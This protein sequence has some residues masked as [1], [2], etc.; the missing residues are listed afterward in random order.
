M[1]RQLLDMVHE[2]LRSSL[3]PLG[4]TKSES[5]EN[6]NVNNATDDKTWSMILDT[7]S[8]SIR[9]E[10]TSDARQGSF[11][12]LFFAAPHSAVC[13]AS[14]SRI[15]HLCNK[16]NADANASAAAGA[17]QMAARRKTQ[18]LLVP[19]ALPGDLEEA[20]I[21]GTSL[22][23][24]HAVGLSES[25][26]K[27]AAEHTPEGWWHVSWDRRAPAAALRDHLN[28]KALPSL[29]II[30]I[31]L[32]GDGATSAAAAVASDR[33]PCLIQTYDG[34]GMTLRDPDGKGFPWPPPSEE[35]QKKKQPPPGPRVLSRTDQVLV[36][37][38]ASNV[39]STASKE[40][41]A[42][43]LSETSL[44]NVHAQIEELIGSL[45]EGYSQ[46]VAA[47]CSHLTPASQP[48]IDAHLLPYL[49][50]GLL[51]E[52]GEGR[53][54]GE[55]AP[56]A[57]P[58]PC[59][60]LN[61][62]SKVT[63]FALAM[64]A[65]IR[66][67]KVCD[68]LLKRGR[69][70]GGASR[71]VQ[72]YQVIQLITN[73]F[74]ETLPIPSGCPVVPGTVWADEALDATRQLKTLE[75]IFRLM[76]T[77]GATWQAVEWPSRAF[78]SERCL[79]AGCMLA[80][81]D[82]VLRRTACD[83]P[84]VVSMCLLE[85]G[86]YYVSTDV[87]QK[88]R[89]F[90]DAGVTMEL[91]NPAHTRARCAVLDYF[92]DVR[93]ACSV[94]LFQ[95][96]TPNDIEV[97]KYGA[98]AGFVRKLIERCGYELIPL[99]H[100]NPP[101]EF[102][103]LMEWL[104]NDGS[105]LNREHIEFRLLRD[106]AALFRFLA[107][108]ET[109][110]AEQMRRK[111]VRE[112]FVRWQ[113]S[114]DESAG[115]RSMYRR[116]AGQLEPL[117]W[118]VLRFRGV[119]KTTADVNVFCFGGRKLFWGEGPVVQSP[120][121]VDMLTGVEACSEDDILYCRKL[122]T[123]EETLS[124]EESE[125]LLSYLTVPYARIPLVLNFFASHDRVTYL[126]NSQ[127]QA[128]FRAVLFEQGPWSS[129]KWRDATISAVPLRRTA[130]QKREAI[131]RELLNG[132]R[133]SYAGEGDAES[134]LGAPWGLLTN[135]LT[136]APAGTLVPFLSMLSTVIEL[137]G[138]SV[139]SKDA[140][141]IMYL[142]DLTIGVE[143]YVV[144]VLFG[145][146]EE[147]IAPRHIK[148]L[149]ENRTRLATFL[150]G[151][152]AD[153]ILR[154]LKEAEEEEDVP[155]TCVLHAS[156]AQ[157]W[158]NVRCPQE[159]DAESFGRI[160]GSLAYVHNWHGFG[161]G[162]LRSQLENAMGDP[163]ERLMR[164]LQAQGIDTKEDPRMSRDGLKQYLNGKPLYLHIGGAT[165]R[166]PNFKRAQDG[167]K[168]PPVDL[169]EARI[170]A[171]LQN[172]RR[173][174]VM[175]LDRQPPD[176]VDHLLNGV[177][178]TA[179]KS[180]S[181]EHV[182]WSRQG[183]GIGRYV[184]EG[185]ELTV[186][187]QAAEVLWRNEELQPV[188]DSMAEFNDFIT[189]FGRAPMQCGVVARQRH[190]LWVRVVGTGCD[191]VEWDAPKP[192]DQGV[193]CP[194]A[195]TEDVN[196]TN[197][198]LGWSC[199]TCTMFN[200]AD[201]QNCTACGTAKAAPKVVGAVYEGINY[202]RP[203]DPY[204]EGPIPGLETH[205]R[206]VERL[207][208]PL[209]LEHYPAEPEDKKMDYMFY[210]PTNPLD[211]NASRVT[212]L[213]CDAPEKHLEDT[214]WKEIIILR[215][216]ELVQLFNL[217]SHGRRMRRNLV[218]ASDT[219]FCLHSFPVDL[220]TRSAVGGVRQLYYAAGNFKK[221]I[222]GG[223]DNTS[224][225]IE[226]T[227]PD[228]RGKEQYLPPRLLQGIV[229][230]VLLESFRLWLGEDGIVRGETV[231]DVSQWFNYKLEIEVRP[232]RNAIVRRRPTTAKFT[233]VKNPK[234]RVDPE[235]VSSSSAENE[236]RIHSGHSGFGINSGPI[237]ASGP[238]RRPF[239]E[240][241]VMTL[242]TLGFSP[243]AAKLALRSCGHSIERAASWLMDPV[244]ASAIAAVD[245]VSS[246][247]VS[248][249][250]SSLN[251]PSLLRVN[252]HVGRVTTLEAE[253][254]STEACEYALNLF[255][256]DAVLAKAWLHDESNAVEISRL[257]NSDNDAGLDSSQKTKK[258]DTY[259]KKNAVKS[260]VGGTVSGKHHHHAAPDLILL[261]LLEA[262]TGEQRGNDDVLYRL[263]SLLARI[264]DLSHVLVWTNENVLEEG[265]ME[266][267]KL[268]KI[269]VIELPRMKLRFQPI[270]D[271]NGVV[272]LHLLGQDGWFVSET[273]SPVEYKDRE[274]S[275]PSSTGL[276][277]RRR[278]ISKLLRGMDNSLIL[279]NHCHQFQV[280]VANHDLHRPRVKGNPFTVGVACDR[281]SVGWQTV[282]QTR[283]YLY[284]VHTSA[285]FLVRPTLS[286]SLYIVLLKFLG[287]DYSAAFRLAC[288]V[289]TDVDFTAEEDWVWQQLRR[290]EDDRHPDAHAVR[291]KLSLAVQYSSN[292]LPWEADDEM[293]GYLSKLPHVSCDC[294]LTAEEELSALKL[295]RT[296]APSIKN[297]I[298]ILQAL[299]EKAGGEGFVGIEGESRTV[300]AEVLLKP[301]LP[302]WG[303]QPWYKLQQFSAAH[304]DA[305]GSS[306]KRLHYRRPGTV[307]EGTDCCKIIWDALVMADEES[308][309]N[310][311]LGLLFLYE[312]LLGTIT[313]KVIPGGP[314]V[315]RSL[316]ELLTRAF[317][318]K[319][320]RWGRETTEDGEQEARASKQMAALAA[321]ISLSADGT[322]QWPKL[323]EDRRSI[324]MLRR[325]V[326]VYV[327]GLRTP[328]KSFV[329]QLNAAF[330][331]AKSS[332][333]EIARAEA[334]GKLVVS[335]RADPLSVKTTE[336]VWLD[337]ATDDGGDVVEN[338]KVNPS[339]LFQRRALQPTDTGCALR[340][341]Q[342]RSWNLHALASEGV[343]ADGGTV[344]LTEAELE[345]MATQPLH[346]ITN[347][348]IALLPPGEVVS[349]DLPFNLDS[350]EAAQP[351]VAR[352]IL[353]RMAGDNAKFA[354]R[355]NRAKRSFM[356]GIVPKSDCGTEA[357]LSAPSSE[358]LQAVCQRM[359]EL[360]Q[361]LEKQQATDSSWVAIAMAHLMEEANS[362]GSSLHT[363]EN[364]SVT[365]RM[366]MLRRHASQEQFADFEFICALLLSS[367]ADV[368]FKYVNRFVASSSS[369]IEL[370][371]AILLKI[372]RVF[373]ANRS[374]GLVLSLSK[375]I[376][377]FDKARKSKVA[378]NVLNGMWAQL[379]QKSAAC[380]GVLCGKRHYFKRNDKS[381]VSPSPNE[382]KGKEKCL[383]PLD[384]PLDKSGAG[385]SKGNHISEKVMITLRVSGKWKG[386]VTVASEMTVGA[387]REHLQGLSGIQRNEQKLILKGKK[388][389]DDAASLSSIGLK[390]QSRIMIMIQRHNPSPSKHVQSNQLSPSRKVVSIPPRS[391]E[392]QSV[393]S[394]PIFTYDPRYLVFEFIFDILLYERQIE[395]VE[396][397]LG[398][399]Q[400]GNSRVQQMIMGAGKTT[401]VAP[402][403][404][405]ILA[406]GKSLVMQ[407]MPTAL[408][409]QTRNVMRQRFSTIMV[410]RVLTLDF[411][412][413]WTDSAAQVELLQAK[414]ESCLRHRDVVCA[415][416]EAVK[417]LVLKFIEL[418][419]SIEQLDFD[420]LV[421]SESLRQREQ[422]R[423]MR[424][425]LQKKS[426]MCDALVPILQMWKE[427]VL[428]MDEVD[429]LL[430][431]LRS[432][433]NFPIGQ[434][435]P[436]DL[437]GPRWDLPI[438]LMDAVV[439]A[440]REATGKSREESKSDAMSLLSM[441][442]NYPEG[443]ST[444]AQ[445][446]EACACLEDLIDA[447]RDGFKQHALQRNPHMVLL[448]RTWY[449]EVFRPAASRWALLWLKRNWSEKE[450]GERDMPSKEDLLSY[451][452]GNRMFIRPG[453]LEKL[454]KDCGGEAETT[455]LEIGNEWD[456]VRKSPSRMIQYAEMLEKLKV[457]NLYSSN[458]QK[459][460]HSLRLRA[461]IEKGLKPASI[462]LL[463]LASEWTQ[464]LL[465]HCLSKIDRVS[466]GILS[467]ADSE[468]YVT[469]STPLS[470]RLM[471]VP[472]VGKDVPSRSSEFAHP[473]VV[474][475]LTILAFRYEG[476]R[477]TDLR[478]ILTQL[479][480]DFSRETGPRNSRP[481]SRTFQKWLQLT[482][483]P[484]SVLPLHLFQPGD[485]KQLNHLWEMVR[486]LPQLSHY[487]L[488][489]HV[490]PAC[491]N[492]QEEKISAC[493]HE[494]GSAILFGRRVGFSGTPS[495][496]L[497][498]D[499][500]ECLYEPGSDGK[501]L[502]TLC[503]QR[504]TT[505]EVK[506]NWSAKSLLRDVAA[507][508][509]EGPFHAL[510][511]TGA[512]IT[513]MDNEQV[514]RFL[515]LHLP[516]WAEGVVF[517]D[518]KDRKIV[519]E[520]SSGR[521]MP[522]AQCG[523]KHENR[524]TF[525]DQV[526]TTGMDIKQCPSAR[527]VVTIGKDMSFRDYAQGAFRMRGIGKGQRIKLFIIPEVEK[528]IAA[529]L[530][531]KEGVKSCPELDVPAWLLTNSMKL[532]CLQFLQLCVQELY[533]VW[534]R[535]ALRSLI[536]DVEE[537]RTKGI[538]S[539]ARLRRFVPV[540]NEQEKVVRCQALRE[541]VTLFREPVSYEIEGCVPGEMAF[542]R[543]LQV[544]VV[545]NKKFVRHDWEQKRISSVLSRVAEV[546]D[547]TV[548]AQD[549][550]FDSHRVQENEQQ[551]QQEKMKD[552]ERDVERIQKLTRE[553]EQH[554]P[555]NAR[556]LA[557]E[558]L[559]E[560]KSVNLEA[561]EV[562][563]FPLAEF[564]PQQG[565]PSLPFPA[566]A[567]VTDNW[568]RPSWIGL[569][570]RR[571]KNIGLLLEW[572]PQ[573]PGAAAKFRDAL[574]KFFASM[575][576][577]D[578]ANAAAAKALLAAIEETMKGPDTDGCGERKEDNGRRFVVALSLA[579]GETI[580]R[581]IHANHPVCCSTALAIKT[582]DG[583][584]VDS[585]AWY[586]ESK[587]D[588]KVAVAIQC[589]RF[590]DNEF[591][592]TDD[593]L[594]LLSEGL[595]RASVKD[596]KDFFMACLRLRR[597]QRQLFADTSLAKVLTPK[598]EWHLLKS[599]AILEQVNTAIK[600][601]AT[602]ALEAAR[603][604]PLQA[605]RTALANMSSNGMKSPRSSDGSKKKK[606]F[607]RGLGVAEMQSCLNSMGLGFSPDVLLEVSKLAEVWTEERFKE[608]FYCPDAKTL[609]ALRPKEEASSKESSSWRC[610]NC[611]FVNSVFDRRCAVCSRGVTG[612]RVPGDDEWSCETCSFF[613]ST[614][615]YF[616]EMCN[617]S[618]AEY[619]SIRF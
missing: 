174:L 248:T 391:K 615:S 323:P 52:D 530:D 586:D 469:E 452:R 334:Y 290:C 484:E 91:L 558:F 503:S 395:M 581:V 400:S 572:E 455:L 383:L 31:P 243:D 138:A 614:K 169:P 221:R 364:L 368:D 87:C 256:D 531:R 170:F 563:F 442:S 618:R 474:I 53:Y 456:V 327:E 564:T 550:G 472:F 115:S 168:L 13:R 386:N 1:R 291:L 361:R 153:I 333:F 137:G 463:Q 461:S 435:Q 445:K 309:S 330:S 114:F 352:D 121:R 116:R 180:D 500:G 182:G 306:L 213:G 488:R 70:K 505:A 555:W 596:R 316:G 314:D 234:K 515:L 184:A 514:A 547:T 432:E 223:P 42:G 49:R 97:K 69:E 287:R 215:D 511:D 279:E 199:P 36:K 326:N 176:A 419:V 471:A 322:V 499:L 112:H 197:L 65:M 359:K 206:W 275:T 566:S 590:V 428:I 145:E 231:D 486:F 158:S 417:C 217:V 380:A 194:R 101:P 388:I 434:K 568:F 501:I 293:A 349:S 533:N 376:I 430:H 62:P 594:E 119:D 379:L 522:L 108:M 286:S 579:E 402:L 92:A 63:S 529:E 15:I 578:S 188:P 32:K 440:A 55:T 340:K 492:F 229:P 20:K 524:F 19:T 519:L 105:K 246:T 470:R 372:S 282:M 312:I 11:L 216:R 272:R 532:E 146:H 9:E 437:S 305:T 238:N 502:H 416:P 129:P 132:T 448:D 296:G 299:A 516:P 5:V 535:N 37:Y 78:D 160:L 577:S 411:D 66:C 412:R 602:Q 407:T 482:T 205:E 196:G 111:T 273:F 520:R 162:M 526:H 88:A 103:A 178:Q 107:T 195:L 239:N 394:G 468:N 571:L 591:Y 264:E 366:H 451:L 46:P 167:D 611:T 163:E 381:T 219:R 30:S 332:P 534:R 557:K 154:W 82:A 122:P 254:F 34:M 362:I 141:F 189:I 460:V 336:R 317:H 198:G 271:S 584:L 120:A 465:P 89:S 301:P 211:V 562:P 438:E 424:E 477:L 538:T 263:S 147:K 144:D 431:P 12:M 420:T 252:S 226:R 487:Y 235:E 283:Y 29:V 444:D 247:S 33:A 405:L 23:D 506:P 269:A 393:G 353:Q 337:L 241:N 259:E 592:Y 148:V 476:V 325:G 350:H 539:S 161:Q 90:R 480:M 251:P 3:Q 84:L 403:L 130:L 297:R 149:Q 401:T 41:K 253:G 406:D 200:P 425:K 313:L 496:L 357:S 18:V 236:I 464:E 96:R 38:A 21:S 276:S 423:R 300:E 397:F 159:L 181:F 224:L 74:T 230:S 483:N 504:V 457:P 473:D 454:G 426:N 212:L 61:V 266:E 192:D 427:G 490:F 277:L 513:G 204:S 345:A 75:L 598:S 413:G 16:I 203:F 549:R 569:G 76:L 553:D 56:K 348:F 125:L 27:E 373:Q 135:E 600:M 274:L 459:A 98:T 265:K 183:L 95:L 201:A 354:D 28:V 408:L 8:D 495:N 554:N 498:D 81:F 177:I 123:W 133:E 164:F 595:Q 185:A 257:N 384:V 370:A 50:A 260:E 540:G 527:A 608:T 447:I 356:N 136:C 494:L 324:A 609:E 321:V 606:N 551:Q 347:D 166:A 68:S 179:L 385:E 582:R 308:G 574:P 583:V 85:D 150:R 409:E 536:E 237:H 517:L 475:G 152:A 429:V 543:E 616:C 59:N 436:I 43:R 561:G 453:M 284:P 109:R 360:V 512:L 22:D 415:A 335:L 320:S 358:E 80:V 601:R 446:S 552:I 605:F 210:L 218:Y 560:G 387:L 151:D 220:S 298:A 281:S 6:E 619:A 102:E 193:G 227:N 485:P 172:Q 396:D 165:V 60:M 250:D 329:E 339:F 612:Q 99:R 507:G 173:G 377:E 294:R 64:A 565:I 307:L 240:A 191:L 542:D 303:G 10:L 462:K 270:A 255:G 86:G 481:S 421:P 398:A 57:P 143:A 100:P 94:P 155:T 369:L 342:A 315:S 214:T 51:L 597:R 171:Q 134:L 607:L 242:I 207:L 156:L 202:S 617:N 110:E 414:L 295:A 589:F 545:A 588:H 302:R 157:L 613:N 489:Q 292:K 390:D 262:G 131:V 559:I 351:M 338:G 375:S 449:G 71:L 318:L 187:V 493:G 355:M 2:E 604:D 556:L 106:V 441:L 40:Y 537:A 509:K 289:S 404:A 67:D 392:C 546:T 479:K 48:K 24:P 346:S 72:H 310:R 450:H 73:L 610:L 280:L 518:R 128:L 7:C 576:K 497:P 344:A 365:K 410:K 575:S 544:E 523:I 466:Y 288:A 244:N 79:V 478:M 39:A 83:A 439:I 587:V 208:R 580:R 47:T 117:R 44:K 443:F 567:V 139:Y 258:N 175:W 525:Y 311:Q 422:M 222:T 140:S 249:A 104:A 521:L 363:M 593:E 343:N 328:I 118:E 458:I 367:Q 378:T 26:A 17:Q 548:A 278:Q 382:T 570:L 433:L 603:L 389:E 35:E 209:L 541:C 319:L 124:R 232:S 341:L 371:A 25:A 4:V 528:R 510:I 399:L 54:A 142:I 93:R 267:D 225:V 58:D 418:L 245:G 77:F 228:I 127:L 491:M 508:D 467:A 113:L 304:L 186:D 599:R 585:S 261:N 14:A 374:A 190:R 45:E 126:F 285:A 268:S 573:H 331:Q 233:V